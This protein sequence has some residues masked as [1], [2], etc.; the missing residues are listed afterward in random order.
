[1]NAHTLILAAHGGGDESAANQ[2]VRALADAVVDH[3]HF[4]NVIVAFNLG[5]P[6]F[7]DVLPLIDGA[8]AR[9]VPVM[10]SDGYF[11]RVLTR[12]LSEA[13]DRFRGTLEVTPPIGTLPA[14]GDILAEHVRAALA[15]FELNASDSTIVVVGHGTRRHA[16]SGAATHALRDTLQEA[17]SR[18][19]VC[20]AFID[21]EPLLS[22]VAAQSQSRNLVI[23]PFFIG[24]GNHEIVD[25][26]EAVGVAPDDVR[27]RPARVTIGQRRVVFT[28]ALGDSARLL[29]LIEQRAR[30]DEFDVIRPAEVR[31]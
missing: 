16:Q 24:G 26:P 9:V 28:A 17:F 1:M 14:V 29:E 27:Q 5:T 20:P 21:Q 31:A 2:R 4:D 7:S 30:G 15:R 12:I 23:A 11:R 22:A 13:H 19:R 10:T 25:I 8:R 18:A 6:H 3:N